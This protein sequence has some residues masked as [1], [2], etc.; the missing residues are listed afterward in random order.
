[1]LT[2]ILAK[3][4]HKVRGLR[5]L[6]RR[7]DQNLRPSV[8]NTPP[9]TAESFANLYPDM[10]EEFR[11]I[12]RACKPFTTTSMERGYALYKAVEYVAQAKISGDFV[13]CGVWRGGS[14]MV[15]AHAMLAFGDLRHLHLYDTFAGM[16]A[17]DEVDRTP[18]HDRGAYERWQLAER[19]GHNDWCYAE[20][21]EVQRNLT[22]TGYPQALLHFH[23]GLCEETLPETQQE[24]ISILRLDTDFYKSTYAEMKYLFPRVA[25]GGVLI[26]DDYGHWEGARK[27]IDQYLA[28]CGIALYLSRVDYTGRVAVKS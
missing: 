23:K 18:F 16:T 26:I 6:P 3:L 17:P 14:S 22:S 4:K 11:S 13:E 19:P 7:S 12:W 25:Q 10:E 28:E 27:A 8:Y 1:M 21:E 15:A 5:R 20:L 9:V 24:K 2:A